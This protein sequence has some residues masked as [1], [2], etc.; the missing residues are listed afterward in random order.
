MRGKPRVEAGVKFVQGNFFAGETLLDLA[1]ARGKMTGWLV[2][3]NGT[4]GWSS[5]STPITITA[6]GRTGRC[7]RTRPPGA[8]TGPPGA[9]IRP[10]QAQ[11]S[12][13]CG[14]TGSAA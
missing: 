6:T 13:S 1:D 7:T 12:G 9:R 11:V 2:T 5:A 3:A 14:G 8:R 4:C 10:L